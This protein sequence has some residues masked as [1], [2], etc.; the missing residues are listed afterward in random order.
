MSDF[1]KIF[2]IVGCNRLAKKLLDSGVSVEKV[3][4]LYNKGETHA[5]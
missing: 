4:I 2:E 3:K 1:D 5:I